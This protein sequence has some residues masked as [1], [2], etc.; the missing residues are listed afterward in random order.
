[1]TTHKISLIAGTEP[2][3]ATVEQGLAGLDY[4]LQLHY[5][6]SDGETIEAV[7]GAD[8]IIDYMVPM[9]A[10][11]INGIDSARAIVSFGHGFDQIDHEAATDRGIMVVNTAAM[12]TDEVANHAM[13][14][15]LA[16]AGRLV[17]LNTKVKAGGWANTES[18][19]NLIGTV[20]DQ[21]LG[22]VGFGNIARAT[23]RRAAAFRMDLITFDP[24]V[25]PWIARDYDVELVGSLEEL[26]ARSDY[27]SMHVPLNNNTWHL[28]GE[29]LFRAMK[30]TAY[31]I[32]TCRGGTVDEEALIAVLQNGEI[33]GAGLD[34]FEEEPTPADNPLLSMD[35]VI[36]TPHSAGSSAQSGHVGR[37]RLGE[38]TARILNGT[39][40]L[41]LVNPEVRSKLDS[42]PPATNQ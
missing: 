33:A 37:A 21:T 34:V 1:M 3:L 13:M 24:Y 19:R 14:M 28:A 17:Q 25:E 18:D 23:A 38:E 30:Q 32:N 11:V 42:L 10:E 27:V 8:T 7:Q 31:F 22:L 9:P 26:A 20:Y 6:K 2:D 12:C 36:V 29:T 35:N 40:P 16:C 4:D 39:W 41:S 15:I 5:P